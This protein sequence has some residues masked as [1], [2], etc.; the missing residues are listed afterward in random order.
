MPPALLGKLDLPL[1]FR[2]LGDLGKLDDSEREAIL[3]AAANAPD[4]RAAG[5][6]L[7]GGM[8]V[9]RP[10]ARRKS[11]LE[12]MDRVRRFTGAIEDWFADYGGEREVMPLIRDLLELAERFV[13]SQQR[14]A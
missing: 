9:A 6:T 13:A 12:D 4:A 3:D 14:A 11:V 7:R 10:K 8:K 1:T 5:E 2:L